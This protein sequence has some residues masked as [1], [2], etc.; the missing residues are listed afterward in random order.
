MRYE[1]LDQK[2]VR[3]HMVTRA[4]TIVGVT[5]AIVYGLVRISKFR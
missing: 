4:F 5:T 1:N 3:V 2:S